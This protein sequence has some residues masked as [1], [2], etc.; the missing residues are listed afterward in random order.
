MIDRI[1]H[2]YDFENELVH[3][4]RY[5]KLYAFKQF[6]MKSIPQKCLD[7][8]PKECK[9]IDF[10]PRV[11][12]TDSQ[13]GTNYWH[14]LSTDDWFAEKSVVW[15]SSQPMFVYREEPVLTFTDYMSYTGGLISL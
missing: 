1:L 9:T 2:E 6:N 10:Y 12:S 11:V 3:D 15:D 8:C 4:L 13:M 7:Y 5:Y 14:N